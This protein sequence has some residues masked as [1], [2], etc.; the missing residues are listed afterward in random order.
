MMGAADVAKAHFGDAIDVVEYKYTQK[1]NIARCKAM[2]VKNLPCI[3]LN[4]QLRFSSL[5]PNRDELQRAIEAL[6]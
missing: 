2:G 6:L 3:Y 1:E 4:G 5:I